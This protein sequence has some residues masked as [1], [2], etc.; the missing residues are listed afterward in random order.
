MLFYQKSSGILVVVGNMEIPDGFL[1][2]DGF[3]DCVVGIVTRFGQE[4]ILCYDYDNILTKL[5]QD[6]M[7]EE[8]AIEYFDYNIIGSW[9]GEKTPCFIGKLYDTF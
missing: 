6:D 4:P 5:M 8:E 7:N 2:I 1:K 9:M 3:D